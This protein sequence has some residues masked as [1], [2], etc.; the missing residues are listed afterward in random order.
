MDG[1]MYSMANIIHVLLCIY[2]VNIQILKYIEQLTRIPMCIYIYIPSPPQSHAPL[3]PQA[4]RT[5]P[6][7][8]AAAAAVTHCGSPLPKAPLTAPG[9]TTAAVDHCCSGAHPSPPSPRDGPR[10]Q[11]SQGPKQEP[12]TDAPGAPTGAPTDIPNRRPEQRSQE[13]RQEPQTGCALRSQTRARRGAPGAPTGRALTPT[14][15]SRGA[16]T[17]AKIGVKRPAH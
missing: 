7:P 15:A 9:P 17:N 14:W 1:I 11:G 13:P 16:R 2:Y 8:T 12:Q 5:V 10:P 4:P 6:G 3:P